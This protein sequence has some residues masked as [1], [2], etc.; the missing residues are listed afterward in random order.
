VSAYKIFNWWMVTFEEQ[1]TLATDN[2]SGWL[3][4]GGIVF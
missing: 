2:F 4:V 3:L 1:K